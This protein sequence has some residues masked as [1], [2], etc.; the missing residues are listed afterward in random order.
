MSFLV[1]LLVVL[2]DSFGSF[3]PLLYSF[4]QSLHVYKVILFWTA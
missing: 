2:E 1:F 3:L 4:L